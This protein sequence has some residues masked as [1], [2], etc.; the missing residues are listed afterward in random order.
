MLI[1]PTFNE[2]HIGP[3]TIYVWGVMV[4][5]GILV[6][7]LL[8]TKEAKRKKLSQEEIYNIGIIS[9][10]SGIMGSRIVF[11]LE[12]PA[13]LTSFW[14]FFKVWEGGLA[15]H[16][17]FFAAILVGY[18]YIRI[19]KLDFKKYLDAVAPSIAIGHAIG[20]VGCILTGLH[21]G[22]ETTVPWGV[23]QNG[24][25]R[26]LTPLYEMIGLVILFLILTK[27]KTHKLI[28]KK[29]GLLFTFYL[30]SYSA[31]RF[32]VEFFRTDPA[33]YGFTIAQ[34]ITAV[35]F[36]AGA[37]IIFLKYARINQKIRE[38]RWT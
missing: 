6:G 2:I 26:H 14:D 10:I 18:V 17:G 9:V 16:G 25:V 38:A 24:A 34:Y 29:E 30:T 31:L 23:Y 22:K 8:A 5:L 27:L 36:L 19:R 15:F 21:L 35:L 32:F 11:A 28:E 4:A 1:Y 12:N 13:A 3:I 33:Y 7:I 20:R 37:V